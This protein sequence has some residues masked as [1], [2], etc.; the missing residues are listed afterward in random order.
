MGGDYNY[1][2]FSG[3]HRERALNGSFVEVQAV[4]QGGTTGRKLFFATTE[5]IEVPLDEHGHADADHVT[6]VRSLIEVVLHKGEECQVRSER[7]GHSSQ[8]SGSRSE[9]K[10]AAVH[11]STAQALVWPLE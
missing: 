2:T 8:R 11:R 10:W 9:F 3:R 6:E 1:T 4:R 5:I 7:A